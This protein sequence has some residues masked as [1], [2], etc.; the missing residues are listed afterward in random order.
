MARLSER[1][2]KK[3]NLERMHKKKKRMLE[4]KEDNPEEYEQWRL[5]QRKAAADYYYRNRPE[6]LEKA[7]VDYKSKREI[8]N[9]EHSLMVEE[10]KKRFRE[11]KAENARIE[12]ELI[13]LWEQQGYTG[14]HMLKQMLTAQRETGDPYSAEAVS[15]YYQDDRHDDPKINN[16]VFPKRDDEGKIVAE[17]EDER[18]DYLESL[19]D[20][21]VEK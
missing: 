13:G 16:N 12:G 2:K 10:N 19:I 11:M 14:K 3:R 1:E 4:L 9:E 7:A 21:V 20:E 8:E 15:S 18:V 17:T 6:V 5:R